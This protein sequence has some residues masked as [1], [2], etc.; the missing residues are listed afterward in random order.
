MK[1]IVILITFRHVVSVVKIK[2]NIVGSRW[3]TNI[4][5]INRDAFSDIVSGIKT[6]HGSRTYQIFIGSIIL[7]NIVS[8]NET[9]C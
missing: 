7:R 9:T 2:I 3:N 1:P 6:T 5:Q 8:N 4:I